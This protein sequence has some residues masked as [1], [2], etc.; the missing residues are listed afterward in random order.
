MKNFYYFTIINNDK[1]I[2]FYNFNINDRL[3]NVINIIKHHLFKYKYKPNIIFKH[4][5][6]DIMN[7]HTKTFMYIL[8]LIKIEEFIT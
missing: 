5:V 4:I 2:K 3:E 7:N 1:F 8:L 6:F